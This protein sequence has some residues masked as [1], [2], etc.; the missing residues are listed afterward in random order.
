[1]GDSQFDILTVVPYI[2]VGVVILWVFDLF[3]RAKDKKAALGESG[4]F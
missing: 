4:R 2:I 3:K 1:M